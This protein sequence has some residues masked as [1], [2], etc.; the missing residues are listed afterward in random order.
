MAKNNGYQ[1]TRA[2]LIAVPADFFIACSRNAKIISQI[3][4]T[5]LNTKDFSLR[6]GDFFLNSER[7]PASGRGPASLTPGGNQTCHQFFS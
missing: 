2:S 6:F 5:P 7:H 4:A 3:A 1:G